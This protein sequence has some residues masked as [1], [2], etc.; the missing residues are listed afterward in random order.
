[1][2]VAGEIPT[3]GWASA[4][5]LGISP[6]PRMAC[7]GSMYPI[8][9][10]D[11]STRPSESA[12]RCRARLRWHFSGR[13][14]AGPG[15]YPGGLPRQGQIAGSCLSTVRRPFATDP[16][17]S[18]PPVL[19]AGPGLSAIWVLHP[20]PAQPARK[21]VSAR[22]C[23]WPESRSN[24]S[25][26]HG[27]TRV[28]GPCFMRSAG[29]PVHKTRRGPIPPSAGF[30]SSKMHETR[31]DPKGP[32]PGPQFIKQGA[33]LSPLLQVSFRAKCMKQT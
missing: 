3:D 10:R 24:A 26:C 22:G 15:N 11:S 13:R 31:P 5:I 28:T 7:L 21:A 2:A 18:V 27:V 19:I 14:S 4:F 30:F 25:G 17:K 32:R 16:A 29:A 9:S 12:A 23:G 8:Q 1:M 33:A 6:V 20:A